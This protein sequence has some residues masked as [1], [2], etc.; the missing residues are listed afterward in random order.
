MQALHQQRSMYGS[1]QTLTVPGGA[2]TRFKA[3]LKQGATQRGAAQTSLEAAKVRLT[4]SCW[5]ADELVTRS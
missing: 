1:Q 2:E 5:D 3:A 4:A